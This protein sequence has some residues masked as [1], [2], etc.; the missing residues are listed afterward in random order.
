MGRE[1]FVFID[2]S[3]EWKIVDVSCFLDDTRDKDGIAEEKR[4][5]NRK[6][7][8]AVVFRLRRRLDTSALL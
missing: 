1:T 5:R 8:R 6:S 2:R 4:T 7:A 3:E